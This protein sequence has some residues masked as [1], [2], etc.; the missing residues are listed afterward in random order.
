MRVFLLLFAVI[1]FCSATGFA[2]ESSTKEKFKFHPSIQEAIDSSESPK[3]MVL[4]FG[5]SWCPPCQRMRSTTFELLE[6][7]AAASEYLWVKFD[8]D[9]AA[10]VASRYGVV[11]VPTMIVLDKEGNPIGANSGFLTVEK[12]L[13]FV[14]DVIENPA[15]APMSLTELAKKI[16]DADESEIDSAVDLLV[17][18]L[19]SVERT[20]RSGL[21]RV[22][23]IKKEKIKL[24]LSELL[25][26]K[27]LKIRAAAALAIFSTYDL[28]SEFDPFA[29]PALRD[30]QVKAI[31][32]LLFADGS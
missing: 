4:Y 24:R 3:P 11:S 29:K 17:S 13:S 7:E 14:K 12:V 19:S 32:K 15:P 22:V 9:E 25:E 30:Q 6:N 2:Q 5:A 20:E 8:I 21:L 27:Q 18:E 23:K 26:D 1:L 10:E 16:E 31:Q 28:Q